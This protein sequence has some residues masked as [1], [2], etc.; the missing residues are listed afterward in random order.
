MLRWLPLL[1][2]LL[3][4]CRHDQKKSETGAS[5][6]VPVVEIP[7]PDSRDHHSWSNPEEA[8]V[9]HLQLQLTVDF[10]RQILD[11]Q[12]TY[13]I[14]NLGAKRI[15]FDIRDMDILEVRLG[16]EQEPG[17]FKLGKRDPILG[18]SLTI[19]IDPKTEM[20]TIHYR[21]RPEAA[22]LQWLSPEQ[23]GQLTPFLYTQSQAIL[24]RSWIP[25]QDSPGV[26]FTYTARVQV[27]ENMLA[28]M[29]ARNP[30]MKSGDGVYLF[31]M[32]R[33]IPAYLLALAVGD[34]EYRPYGRRAGVYAQPNLL[35]SAAWEF[36]DTER[37][38]EAAESM[39]GPYQWER[40]DILVLPPSFPFGGMENPLLTFVT[41]SILAGDRSLT[42]LIAHELAHSW[43][44]NLVTNATW[45]DF[46]LNEGFTVYLERR[47]ME[48]LYGKDMRDMLA[49]LGQQG[50]VGVMDSKGWD[51]PDTRLKLNL[52]GRDPDEALTRIAYEKGFL[53]LSTIEGLY[54]REI[55]DN[56]LN[57][58]FRRRAFSSATSEDFVA[59]LRRH[60]FEEGKALRIEEWVYGTAIPD[61]AV[62]F[63]SRLFDR[64]DAT[65]TKY[66]SDGN[67]AAVDTSGW[68]A[69]MWIHFLRHLPA[70]ADMAGLDA[71]FGLSKTENP[72]I[73][74]AWFEQAITKGY[75]MT[76]KDDLAEFL[77]R[78]GRRKFLTPLYKAML[79][80]QMGAEAREIYQRARPGYH[81]VSRQTL[82]KLMS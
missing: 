35:L 64:V 80:N 54:S 31:N 49:V 72:E 43:S 38:M 20:V 7:E 65:L 41:P 62:S 71:R 45:N 8:R 13:T 81:H 32:T 37:M 75:G 39:F 82:D 3:V 70:N 23:A 57:D 55:L 2:L 19:P 66:G 47:I 29:S 51:S 59:H 50:M 4:A 33:P 12:A 5:S 21:T 48:A 74:F 42:T 61:N 69:Q 73:R 16:D 6:R 17:S 9:I 14:E 10:G 27:P 34:I 26:R 56:L 77:I 78:H 53:F 76:L 46:W 30:T 25:C 79:D 24:A 63:G 15:V 11:G 58:W 28:L 1:V 68:N 22:A 36:D 67:S 52:R 44:G 18:Q 40:Y 60:L